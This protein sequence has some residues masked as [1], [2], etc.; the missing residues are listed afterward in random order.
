MKAKDL[1]SPDDFKDA[2]EGLA[3]TLLFD[4]AGRN[5]LARTQVETLVAQLPLAA[6]LS[7]GPPD[8]P[9]APGSGGAVNRSKVCRE[10]LD[11]VMKS[12]FEAAMLK[13]ANNDAVVVTAVDKAFREL[14]VNALSTSAEL[15]MTFKNRP[16]TRFTFGAGAAVIANAH[17]NRVRTKIDDKSGNL[18]SDPLPRVM[19][20]AFVN[21]SPAGYN[22]AA[23]KIS[24]SERVRPFFG[25]ALTPDFGVIGGVNVLLGRGIGVVSG[26]GW[27]FGKGAE[28]EE[29]GKPPAAAADPFKLV[30]SRSL[31]F[32][33]S[34]SYK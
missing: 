33:I 15:K 22:D 18:V 24:W 19:T 5:A 26:I 27:L 28:A 3:T 23:A 7:C 34:Y 13:A 9:P 11:K 21:W 12:A 32:G 14:A 8:A 31:F 10:A 1:V 4:G 17:L 25:A 29:I 2:V 30:V 20:M 6:R 16:L